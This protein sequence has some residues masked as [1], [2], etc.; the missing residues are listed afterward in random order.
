M[1]INYIEPCSTQHLTTVKNFQWL[2]ATLHHQTCCNDRIITQRID[3]KW[4]SLDCAW[5][6]NWCISLPCSIKWYRLGSRKHELRHTISTGWVADRRAC[7][8]EN[9]LASSPS[10]ISFNAS[11]PTAFPSFKLGST[12]TARTLVGLA[13]RKKNNLLHYITK[14]LKN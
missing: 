7:R 4:W 3:L 11:F 8:T 13:A 2:I 6:L 10:E 9:N 14:Q 5:A 12:Y 1:H